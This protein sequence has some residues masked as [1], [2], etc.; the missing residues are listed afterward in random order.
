MIRATNLGVFHASLDKFRAALAGHGAR[1]VRQ[2]AVALF[3]EVATG[4]Q[5][6]PGTPVD[7]GY[8][9]ANWYAVSGY[10]GSR[11]PVAGGYGG[12]A[13]AATSLATLRLGEPVLIANPVPYIVA[14]E[15]GT[16][17]M[18][19]RGFVRRAVQAW[20]QIAA[21]VAARLGPVLK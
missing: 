5:Y 3:N 12:A 17:R 8:A 11:P 4:G 7:T 6:S 16:S 19:P 20:P 13:G 15:Y 18:A 14:L 21:T 10:S 2:S 1:F 9:R